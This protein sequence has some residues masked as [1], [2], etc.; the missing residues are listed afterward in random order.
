V[1]AVHDRFT[2][3]SVFDGDVKL[4]GALGAVVSGAAFVVTLSVELAAETLSAASFALTVKL[5][6]VLAVSPVAVYVVAP[7]VVPANVPPR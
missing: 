2:V 1:E 6:A 5:Y 3:V 7:V 4:V